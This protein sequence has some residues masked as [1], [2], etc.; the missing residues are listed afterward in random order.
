M[1]LFW[2]EPELLNQAS[3]LQVL[4]LQDSFL[5]VMIQEVLSVVIRIRVTDF[6]LLQFWYRPGPSMLPKVTTEEYY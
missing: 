1:N 6:S 5:V 2:Q 4:K 3:Y